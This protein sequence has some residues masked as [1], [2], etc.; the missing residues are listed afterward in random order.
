MAPIV[1]FKNT[2]WRTFCNFCEFNKILKPFFSVSHASNDFLLAPP[3]AEQ[4]KKVSRNRI[5][6]TDTYTPRTLAPHYFLPTRNIRNICKE[7]LVVSKSFMPVVYFTT[8][9]LK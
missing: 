4:A 5:K 2:A 1:L 6:P 7:A 3:S 8:K 9:R